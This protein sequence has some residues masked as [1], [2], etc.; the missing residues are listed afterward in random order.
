MR[1]TPKKAGT[2][3]RRE[4]VKRGALG[5]IALAAAP[6]LGCRSAAT[7]R[8]AHRTGP[9]SR[10]IPLD[11][12]WLFGGKLD[13]A[14]L[15]PTFNDDAFARVSLPHSVAR[16]S[17]QNWEPAAWQDI[18]IYRRLFTLPSECQ[19]LR[20]FLHFDGVMVGA[21]PTINGH[22]LPQ[23]LGGY[24]PFRYELTEWLAEGDN[25]LAVAVDSRWSDVPPEGS[26]EGAKRIDYLEPGGIYRSVRLESVP[27]IFISDVF[28]KPVKVLDADRRIE[29]LCAMNS[30]A[31]SCAVPTTRNPRRSWRRATNWV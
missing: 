25:V 9:A 24:L 5:A 27:Q 10:T 30:T 1:V 29:V 14:A 26:K 31:T 22:T 16:L 13:P 7:R 28:A 11:Q 15:A 2:V 4:F 20:T 17:W 18:W 21:T 3:S 12:D 6:V 19:R 23:H 8:T